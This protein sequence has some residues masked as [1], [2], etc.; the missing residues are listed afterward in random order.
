MI[1]KEPEIFYKLYPYDFWLSK[2]NMLK[3]KIDSGSS[4]QEDIGVYAQGSNDE[5]YQR[6]LK[7]ELHFTYFQQVEAIF[8]LLFALQNLDDKYIWIY[9]S[10]ADGR[11]N[12]SKIKSISKGD[13]DLNEQEV[14]LTNGETRS[15]LEWA[16]Y[17]SKNHQMSEEELR[18]HIIK[19]KRLLKQAA[20][21]FVD[22]ESYNS[23]KHGLRILPLLGEVGKND[24]RLVKKFNN[25]DFSNSFTYLDDKKSKGLYEVTVTYDPNQDIERIRFMSLLVMNMITMRRIQFYNEETLIFTKFSKMDPVERISE[26]HQRIKHIDKIGIK[27]A[28]PPSSK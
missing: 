2:A 5:R 12:Y 15:F 16:F 10:Q 20:K 9:L 4:T 28:N 11:E 17:A 14:H 13:L 27:Y 19:S 24:P 18:D 23:Y 6:M 1:E 3:E 7:Y 22:R 26:S 8:E 25:Q 21:D